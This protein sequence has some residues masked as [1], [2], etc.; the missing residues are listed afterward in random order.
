MERFFG[1]RIQMIVE[2]QTLSFEV[3]HDYMKA[4]GTKPPYPKYVYSVRFLGTEPVSLPRCGTC[5]EPGMQ[6]TLK[7]VNLKPDNQRNPAYRDY[8][9]LF[10]FRGDHLRELI[11]VDDDGRN[12]ITTGTISSTDNWCMLLEREAECNLRGW[13]E[14]H[15][16]NSS[17][18]ERLDLF[19][20]VCCGLDELLKQQPD[21][22]ELRKIN[23][24]LDIKAEN[25]LLEHTDSGWHVRLSDFATVL[26]EGS[27][28]FSTT[29]SSVIL[30][31]SSTPPEIVDGLNSLTVAADLYALGILLIELFSSENPVQAWLR[32]KNGGQLDDN[33]DRRELLRNAFQ[34]LGQL[35]AATPPIGGCGWLFDPL[36]QSGW[37]WDP[38]TPQSIRDIAK[39]LVEYDPDRRMKALP[40]PA[41]LGKLEFILDSLPIDSG[42]SQSTAEPELEDDDGDFDWFADNT[43]EDFEQKLSS[44]VFLIN[45][46]YSMHRYGGAEGPLFGPLYRAISRAMEQDR[47]DCGENTC[48]YAV[49]YYAGEG[50][51]IT[52]PRPLA[53]KYSGE[54][55]IADD[56]Q[57]RE[58]LGQIEYRDGG[59]EEEDN[60][61]DGIDWIN[62][63]AEQ[64]SNL[65]RIHIF[66]DHFAL[67]DHQLR[68]TSAVKTLRAARSDIPFYCH[69]PAE[70]DPGC[71]FDIINREDRPTVYY[72]PMHCIEEFGEQEPEDISWQ[73]PEEDKDPRDC[74]IQ[75]SRICELYEDNAFFRNIAKISGEA[76]RTFVI[77][78]RLIKA[79]GSNCITYLA[80]EESSPG[81]KV[82]LKE[83]YPCSLTLHR[84]SRTYQLE[85]DPDNAAAMETIRS[86]QEKF[87]TEITLLQNLQSSRIPTANC[88]IADGEN[89]YLVMQ[90]CSATRTLRDICLQ[91]RSVLQELPT[92]RRQPSLFWTRS[93]L[94]V[95]YIVADVT[96][97]LHALGIAHNDLVMGNVLVSDSFP[98]LTEELRVYLIDFSEARRRGVHPDFKTACI[99]DISNFTALAAD[100]FLI[101]YG[102]V[103]N[104]WQSSGLYP[105]LLDT[106]A[107]ASMEE[108]RDLLA[109]ILK[110]LHVDVAPLHERNRVTS[111]LSEPQQESTPE[112]NIPHTT[113]PF[114]K[115]DPAP[116]PDSGN[117]F[118]LV[119]GGRVIR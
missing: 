6:Y 45:G 69:T 10:P 79:N 115:H 116:A 27:Y 91:L 85:I 15:R 61:C 77:D 98:E 118:E 101:P 92:E 50:V 47:L 21:L 94:Q 106:C 29:L 76:Y 52:P 75:G 97:Q 51:D 96:A 55:L 7:A 78:Q 68:L 12:Y 63:N 25:A 90:Y 80:H 62:R 87:E 112:D 26:I 5:L 28:I 23:A 93:L 119:I 31:L 17:I 70:P 89:R 44:S 72:I 20:Q 83:L 33:T 19:Y 49:V 58:R 108:W 39:Q 22:P 71:G 57:L 66:T 36:K 2:G 102:A 11:A 3:R 107:A 65:R 82:M 59:I 99:R 54:W 48:F 113:R 30:S 35:R 86:V 24:H 16:K 32:C 56:T 111:F 95:L 40:I 67:Q 43:G 60:V 42:R 109:D 34:E 9:E 84:C 38:D 8:H 74:M 13:M 4:R 1:P 41:L 88:L 73:L 117:R 64:I 103:P 104:D 14:Q 18:R 37:H 53:D 81:A 100:C 114:G 105:R 110:E 46:S